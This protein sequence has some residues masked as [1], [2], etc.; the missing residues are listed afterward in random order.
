MN[1]YPV[2]AENWK[3]DGGVAF[4]VVP[5]LI[6]K[7]LMEPDENN[8]VKITTR[9][10]LVEDEN[11]VI[12]FDVGMGKKQNDKY[13]SFRYLFGDDNLKDNLSKIGYSFDD[14]TDIVFT[15]LHDDHCG[16]ATVLNENG[17]SVIAFKNAIFHVSEEHWDWARKPNKREVGSFFPCS[18]CLYSFAIYSKCRCSTTFN[19]KRKGDLFE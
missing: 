13:Y 15:H 11:R 12:L 6:W 18:S 16:A 2:I 10:L 17:D 14:I 4:G 1:I 8:M 19:I 9:C 5:R 7:K 3:M